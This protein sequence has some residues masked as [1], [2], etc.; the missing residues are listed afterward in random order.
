M[1]GELDGLNWSAVAVSSLMLIDKLPAKAAVSQLPRLVC[2]G[3]SQSLTMAPTQLLHLEPGSL[4]PHCK[5]LE[6][7]VS[8]WAWEE[9]QRNL[10]VCAKVLVHSRKGD[11][12]L[13]SA[14]ALLL[15]LSE[16]WWEKKADQ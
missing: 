4:L 3:T 16:G 8:L 14:Q 10:L 15:P 9:E 6:H 13:L 12:S 1:A 11:S 7:P 2:S 5:S